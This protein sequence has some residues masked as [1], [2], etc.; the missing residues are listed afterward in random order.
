MGGGGGVSCPESVKPVTISYMHWNTHIA[1][2]GLANTGNADNTGFPLQSSQRGYQRR[3]GVGDG[4]VS[5]TCCNIH[6]I[7][8]RQVDSVSLPSWRQALP[9]LL[10]DDAFKLPALANLSMILC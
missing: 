6:I 3:Y 2:T 7:C 10:E 4:S 9:V 8:R 1:Y 5:G